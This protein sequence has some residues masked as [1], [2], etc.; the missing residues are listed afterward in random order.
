MTRSSCLYYTLSNHEKI[1]TLIARIRGKGVLP[2]PST[3]N[4]QMMRSKPREED[5]NVKIVL[6]SGMVVIDDKVKQLE[7]STWVHKALAK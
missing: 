6:Q 3:Q 1:P 4:L 2:S 7:D 5:P